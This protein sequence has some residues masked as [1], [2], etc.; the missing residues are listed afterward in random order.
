[1]MKHTYLNII[2]AFVTLLVAFFVS[3]TPLHSQTR[4]VMHRP[5]VDQRPFHYGF[6]A[7]MQF[8]DIE[9]SQNGYIDVGSRIHGCCAHCLGPWCTCQSLQQ[10]CRQLHLVP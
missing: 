3:A 8:M 6:L 5:Y 2:G 10:P 4:K 1:M 9:F 7:G